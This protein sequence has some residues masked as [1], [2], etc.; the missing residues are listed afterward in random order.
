M[1]K[2]DFGSPAVQDCRFLPLKPSRRILTSSSRWSI[3]LQALTLLFPPG[4]VEL[5]L[6]QTQSK[7][8]PTTPG[9]SKRCGYSLPQCVFFFWLLQPRQL[10]PGHRRQY[11]RRSR[12]GDAWDGASRPEAAEPAPRRHRARKSARLWPRLRDGGRKAR[13]LQP[14]QTIR[15]RSDWGR[16]H[17]NCAESG[18]IAPW[19]ERSLLAPIDMDVVWPFAACGCG[20]ICCAAEGQ[21]GVLRAA[22]QR[23]ASG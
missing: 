9:R 8:V 14:A 7:I 4:S 2:L 11:A 22:R 21:I 15:G 13:A 19:C 3:A 20:R 5:V 16:R 17:A 1:A 12:I 6:Q 10:K 18:R 23:I